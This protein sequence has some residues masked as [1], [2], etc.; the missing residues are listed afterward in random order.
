[1][2][3]N[4]VTGKCSNKDYANK[5]SKILS[6]GEGSARTNL[7]NPFWNTYFSINLWLWIE[8]EELGHRDPDQSFIRVQNIGR[9]TTTVFGRRSKFIFVGLL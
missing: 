6:R 9:T 7:L 2:Q 3:Q 5:I 8:L 4:F 1:M